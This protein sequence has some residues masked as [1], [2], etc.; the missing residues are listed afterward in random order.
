MT[1]SD[2][3]M[4]YSFHTFPDGTELPQLPAYKATRAAIEALNGT[5]LEGTGEQVERGAIDAEGRF[6]RLATGWG[7]L[8]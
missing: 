1:Q 2:T 5:L 8:A 4:V 3:V 7:E 6:R